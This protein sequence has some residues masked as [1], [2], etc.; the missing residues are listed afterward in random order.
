L[1]LLGN[2]TKD[3]D[4][5]T[6]RNGKEKASFGV[7][8][9]KPYKDEYGEWQ[10]RTQFH[11]VIAW[12][13]KAAAAKRLSKGA[14]VYVQGELTHREY[15]DKNGVKRHITEVNAF[16]VI[17]LAAKAEGPSAPEPAYGGQSAGYPARQRP[18]YGGDV[19][20]LREEPG[21]EDD[22]PL[23][24]SGLY[25]GQDGGTGNNVDIPF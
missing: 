16:E 5:S 9:G 15:E 17:P 19:G 21:F 18:P 22:F 25:D 6:T 13:Y 3:P 20:S 8:T 12:E 7:A 1:K 23:D 4:I 14:R 11:N 2:C 10:E 24:V